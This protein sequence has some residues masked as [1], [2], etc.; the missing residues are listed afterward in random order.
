MDT[1]LQEKVRA[2][3]LY[4]AEN[5]AELAQA[6]W[7]MIK[8]LSGYRPLNAGQVLFS[9][10]LIRR[11]EAQLAAGSLT[12]PP[13]E[14]IDASLAAEKREAGELLEIQ[15]QQRQAKRQPPVT[16][17]GKAPPANPN[18]IS[19]YLDRSFGS[20]QRVVVEFPY[21]KAK[22]RAVQALKDI[23]DGWA[24]DRHSKKEWSYPASA[25]PLVLDALAEFPEF[26]LA[27]G[28]AQIAGESRFEES[29]GQELA[30]LE[31]QMLSL[32]RELALESIHP[33]TQ[34]AALADGKAL[35]QHQREAVRTLISSQRAVLAHDLGLGKTRTALIAAKAYELPLLV[36]A[37]AGLHI[38]WMREA[39]AAQVHIDMLISWAKIPEPPEYDYILVADEAHYAQNLDSIRTQAFLKLAELAH[40]V[41]PVTGT[42]AKNAQPKNLFPLLAAIRHP[43]ASNQRKYEEKYCAGH[44]RKVGRKNVVW[45]AS[46]ASNLD[47]LHEQIKDLVLYKKKEECLDLPAKTRVMR[48][49]E[50]RETVFKEYQKTLERLRKEHKHRLEAK[51]EEHVRE[52]V[53]ELGEEKAESIDRDALEAELAADASRAVALVEMG[54]LRHAGSLA[55]VEETVELAQ[56]VLDEAQSVVI[57]TVYRDTADQLTQKLTAYKCEL[58]TGDTPKKERQHFIDQFQAG[59]IRALVCT[60]GAGGVGITLTAAQTVILVDRPWTPGDCVQCEDRLH[61]IGQQNAVTS[62]W[63]QF[64]ALDQRID[65]LLGQKQQRIDQVLSGKKGVTGELPSIAALAPEIMASIYEDTPVEEFL[66]K[67]GLVLPQDGSDL[68]AEQAASAGAAQPVR[69]QTLARIRRTRRRP[70]QGLRLDGGRDQRVKGETVRKRVNMRLDAEVVAFL[71]TI[72][73]DRQHTTEESGYSGFVEELVRDS[74]AFQRWQQDQ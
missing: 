13:E 63:L 19:L 72:K 37:P 24:F 50:A 30:R 10:R 46:G 62:L 41:W 52:L 25:T 56:E 8:A 48:A 32:E 68:E 47:E 23:V 44:F 31:E 21:D 43:L 35:Y 45:D 67:Y 3:L 6:E 7:T 28:V 1:S 12:L 5:R 22:V 71:R 15:V 40:A 69:V 16:E 38:N 65:A 18:R 54:M 66:A 55:K 64:G 70:E 49:A 17:E 42:P 60:V 2:C 26:E 36:I 59:E 61:R 4:L 74:E 27:P 34:G 14:A 33:Y 73:T 51:V 9:S 53:R 29:I 11:Y 20:E 57:F 39:E 58:L